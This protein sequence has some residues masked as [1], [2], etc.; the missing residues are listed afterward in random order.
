MFQASHSKKTTDPGSVKVNDEPRS[1]FLLELFT[2][3][4][5][6][7]VHK[8]FQ[9]SLSRVRKKRRQANGQEI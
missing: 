5:G 3:D 7:H 6:S 1:G 8:A 2:Y 4:T 9:I